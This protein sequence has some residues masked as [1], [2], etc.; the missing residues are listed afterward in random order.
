MK[1]PNFGSNIIFKESSTG[2]AKHLKYRWI[3]SASYKYPDTVIIN[4]NPWWLTLGEKRMER[5]LKR[6]LSHEVIHNILWYMDID[7][8]L[9]FLVRR[10]RKQT[11]K[12]CKKT[13]EDWDVI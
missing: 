10:F 13:W 6:V 11:R 1:K 3:A 7:G 4:E 9:D 12:Q 2:T 8:K 5:D